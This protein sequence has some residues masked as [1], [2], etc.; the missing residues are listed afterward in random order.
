VIE[1]DDV[2][3]RRST[4]DG[5]RDDFVVSEPLAICS[6]RDRVGPWRIG[7]KALQVREG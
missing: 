5:M 3:R 7:R 6:I 2:S 1:V 4:N